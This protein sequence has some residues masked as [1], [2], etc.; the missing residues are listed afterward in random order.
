MKL[1]RIL[2]SLTMVLAAGVAVAQNTIPPNISGTNSEHRREMFEVGMLRFN[3]QNNA[4]TA[5]SGGAQAGTPLNMGYNRFT[6]IA[7]GS[8][9]A[10]LP[11]VNGAVMVIVTNAHA[12]NALAVFPQTGG[13]IN[14]ASAN[15]AF[16]VTAGKTAIFIQAVDTS[17][18]TIWYAILTA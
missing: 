4:M 6:T 10:Q 17:G 8:D 3:P 13:I 2:F 14:A 11:T 16:S 18:G 12:S 15:T 9:S 5:L 1:K 7:A